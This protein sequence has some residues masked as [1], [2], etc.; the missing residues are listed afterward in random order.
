MKQDEPNW[1]M[2]IGSFGLLAI[3]ALWAVLVASF[4]GLIGGLWWPIQAAIYL[5]AGIAWVFPAMPLM[6][7]MVT[8]KWR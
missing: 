5:A 7:W 2:P 8:G 1:R 3:I 4:S 6:R